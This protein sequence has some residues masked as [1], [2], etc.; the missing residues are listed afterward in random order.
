LKP[1]S[2]SIIL[3]FVCLSIA[4]I[5]LI[6]QLTVKLKP[7][8]ELPH[9][10]VS[11]R[12]PGSSPRVVEMETTSKLE[13][14]LSRIKGVRNIQ[15][16]SGRGRGSI[17]IDFDKDID[18][19]A[20]RFEV[21]TVV[22]QT[23]PF[24]PDNVS[25][26]S[27]S[28]ARSDDDAARPFITYTVNAPAIPVVISQYVENTIKP[29]LAQIKGVNMVTVYGSTP[30]EWQLEYDHRQLESLGLSPSDIRS[31]IE[32]YLNRGL[33][34]TAWTDGA[35]GAREWLRI[36]FAP[37]ESYED[38]AGFMKMKIAKKNGQLIPLG[39]LVTI[40]HRQAEP[41]SYYRING[42]NSVTI[43][44][45]AV[46]TANQLEL[47]AMVKAKM[48]ELEAL[49]PAGYEIHLQYDATEYIG[50]ELDKVYF[51]SGLT[52]VILLLFV[53]L[54]YRSLK[55]LLM[56]T[57]SLVMNIAIAVIF[58]Y[59][60]G[61]EIQLYSLAGITISLTLVIDNTI[62][63]SD[64]II[65][66]RN[67]NA[68][69][70]ILAATVTTIAAMVIIF[71][72]DEKIRLNLLD[73]AKVIMINLG[74]SLF[75]AL[76]LVPALI[77]KLKMNNP[78]KQK[79]Q[80]HLSFGTL[81][82]V[83]FNRFYKTFCRFVW[84]RKIPVC[85]IIVLAFGLPVYL[86]PDKIDSKNPWADA[87]N[88]TLGTTVYKEKI[89][90][91]TDACLG[92]TLRLFAKKVS[93]IGYNSYSEGQGEETSIFVSGTLPN[94]STLEQMNSLVKKMESF[95]SEHREIKTFTTSVQ[96]RHASINIY[97][98]RESSRTGFPYQLKNELIRKATQ[99]GGGS[100]AVYGLGDGFNNSVQQMAGQ[101]R[102]NI[103]GYN[104]DELI[105]HAEAFKSRLMEHRRIKDV[106]IS[107]RF[108]FYKEDYEEFTFNLNTGTM[109][110]ENINAS[111]LASATE[112]MFRRPVDVGYV[113]GQYGEERIK[114]YSKNAKQYDI[115]SLKHFPGKTGEE[116]EF[117]LDR[118]AN[119][120]RIQAP[121]DIVKENQQY[122][123]CIQ[124]EYIGSSEQGR[125]ILRKDIEDVQRQLP[126]GYTIKSDSEYWWGWGGGSGHQYWLL[127]L[128]F[129]I[130][131]FMCSILFNSLLQPL[132]VI[133]V[134]PVS[135]IGI[136]LTFY[137]FNLRFDEGGFASFILLCGLSVNANIYILNEY[138][139]IR[140]RRPQLSPLNAYIKA[141]NAKIEPIFLTVVSTVLG[142]IPFMV[143]YRESFW[144]PL[145]AG[146]TG[147]LIMSLAG[148]FCFLPLFMGVG[149]N[150][151]S[152]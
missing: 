78:V 94:G 43:D 20:A 59:S 118:L 6:P 101:Y 27:I 41:S 150:R 10:S 122:R 73:F 140:R 63:M 13:A 114:L 133:F 21:S 80:K 23:K 64:Q 129:V 117:K 136:F 95:I 97:F 141:W 91:W 58:Y 100:W 111:G 148:L 50:E 120:E 15:S 102:V 135:F 39:K 85:I 88:K 37:G 107:S 109:A 106:S 93:E 22:R 19:D 52:L 24:L 34:G 142:F 55:Y 68:F 125:N 54:M 138:N 32:E 40:S 149:K 11:F 36:A 65:R 18:I 69:P 2:F 123:L 77:E 44:I 119:I 57:L 87:Y 71:F 152:R 35:D 84:R 81:L 146:A 33:L 147:G 98:T 137:I 16:T 62:V 14:M 49:F 48:K 108:S 132:A 4:G 12:M 131:Y 30:M 31:A 99:L 92:G 3:V 115:W 25:Y 26:P 67:R 126:T 29:R 5:A 127:L 66:R 121:K 74:V 104:Y 139:N 53:L 47:G 79:K 105:K 61:L 7:S 128:I 56:I 51:R 9:I 38:I 116:R 103:Y 17:G 8:R 144:F 82:T 1:S 134:I 60:G 75:A 112:A 96:P 72:L 45:S 90:P 124:Y 145:A 130:T 151:C 46:E 113:T 83:K 143:G 76:F 42:L 70:A 110:A 89:K 86:L 28:Q